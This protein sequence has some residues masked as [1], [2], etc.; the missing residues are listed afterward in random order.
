MRGQ[1]DDGI[2][3]RKSSNFAQTGGI[4]LEALTVSLAIEDTDDR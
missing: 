2:V 4:V 1:K 3:L